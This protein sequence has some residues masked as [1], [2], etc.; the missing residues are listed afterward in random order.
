MVLRASDGA[1][2][3]NAL[4]AWCEDVIATNEVAL[5]TGA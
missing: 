3:R 1:T 4:C 2:R 5:R